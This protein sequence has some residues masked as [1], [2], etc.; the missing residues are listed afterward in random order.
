MTTLSS[1]KNTE[2]LTLTFTAEF[3]AGVQRVW[4]L[5][6]D[7][8]QLE[9]WWGPPTWP[10]TF[11]R[12]DLREGG[13][14]RY[15][16]T[17]PEGDKAHGWWVIT[18]V[19]APTRL[20]FDDGFGDSDGEPDLA[21]DP[22]HATVTLEATGDGTRMSIVSSFTSEEHLDQLVKMGMED[23]MAEALGQIAAIL[24]E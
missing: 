7:P 17:G 16:M 11:T 24:A 13:E 14:S 2:N 22:T 4:E 8:R 10:A 3:D 15:Y 20:E 18:A 23:G 21:I 12:H 6:S 9:R 5:W 1:E 19:D